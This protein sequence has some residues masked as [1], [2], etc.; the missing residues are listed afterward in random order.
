VT[1]GKEKDGLKSK[2][3]AQRPAADPSL[4]QEE[5]ATHT[6]EQPATFY[7]NGS[8]HHRATQAGTIQ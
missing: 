6:E 4:T 8:G 1:L 3:A 2:D 5:S 7:C